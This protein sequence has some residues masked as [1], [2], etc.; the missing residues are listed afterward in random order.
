MEITKLQT[1]PDNMPV[2]DS[3]LDGQTGASSQEEKK[4]Q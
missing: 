4:D 1:R 2:L 3:N